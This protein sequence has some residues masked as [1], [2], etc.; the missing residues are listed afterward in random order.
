MLEFGERHRLS[1]NEPITR[2]LHE[3]HRI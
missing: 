2:K 3:E 1:L